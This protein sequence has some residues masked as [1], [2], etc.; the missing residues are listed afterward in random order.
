[1]RKE[2]S[3][4][5][6]YQKRINRIQ[7]LMEQ[8]S[9]DGMIITPSSDLR[10]LAGINQTPSSFFC[11]LLLSPNRC[12]WL[13]P[14]APAF[15]GNSSF[16]IPTYFYE[17]SEQPFQLAIQWLNNA[18]SIVIHP[19]IPPS[20]LSPLQLLLPSCQWS[21]DMALL[22]QL[23]ML[24]EPEELSLIK[25]A[26]E[27]AEQAIG[28]VLKS[29]LTGKTERQIAQSLMDLRLEIGFDSVG[30]GLIA[31]GPHTA[32]PHHTPTDRIIRK[33]DVVTIDI[34]G[35]Y[36]GYHADMTRSFVVGTSSSQI[37]EI[38]EIVLN[39]FTAAK[40]TA[41]AGIPCSRVDLAGRQVISQA[42]YGP[43]FTHGIG[44]GIGLDVHEEPF[45]TSNSQQYLHSGMVFSIEPGIYIPGAFGIRIEDLFVI[46]K[47]GSTI[48]LN[49]MPRELTEIE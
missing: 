39:A 41:S 49:Y 47:D 14:C 31:S 7:T 25:T 13:A 26:Q 8:N 43:Y 5:S 45:L 46:Q 15:C 37:K 6:I 36:R 17:A 24:K 34:G 11:A 10:Y 3:Q 44:H 27:M 2:L 48:N 4:E 42:G 28:T 38:Y 9:L 30:P 16:F 33:G 40:Q 21:I 19:S 18:R 12:L 29:G 35:E 22:H 32:S 23:R 1:M 20:W